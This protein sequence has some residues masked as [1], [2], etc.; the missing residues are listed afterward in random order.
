MNLP[1]R[2]PQLET[3]IKA[4]RHAGQAIARLYPR[5][6]DIRVKGFRDLVTDGD[7]ASEQA[8]VELIQTRFPEH[9]ILSE[10]AGAG[11]LTSEYTWIIDPLD[12]STNYAHHHPVFAVSVGLLRNGEPLIGVIYNPLSNEIFVAQKGAGATVNDQPIHTSSTVKL[13]NA[14]IAVDWGHT[15]EVRKQMLA[16]VE[17]IL[18]RC[19]TLRAMGSAALATAYVAAGWLDAYFQTG[20]KPW[21]VAAGI[22]LI[23]EAGGQCTTLKGEPYRID[24][25]DCLVT[26]GHIHNDLL[27]LVQGSKPKGKR[28]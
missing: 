23:K 4:A 6:R 3:A 2:N 10:E 26:N 21:D 15:N 18:L 7:M 22:L 13:E 17:P 12:G 5:T 14:M 24:R 27:T 9:D 11:D 8:V 20:L 28:V 25:P 19:G 16:Y 1:Q